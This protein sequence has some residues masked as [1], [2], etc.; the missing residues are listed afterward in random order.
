MMD[1]IEREAIYLWYYLDLQL[2]QIL[3]Y[4]ALGILLGSAV[5]VFGKRWIHGAFAGV[6]RGKWGWLGVV[7]ASL[8]GIASPLCM[9]GTLPIAASFSEKGVRDDHLAAFMM[10]SVL[11]NPQLLMYSAALGQSALLI[12]LA[13]CFLCGCA[14][15]WLVRACCRA[16][17]S[18][19]FAAFMPRRPGYAPQPADTL[20]AQCA[21]QYPGHSAVVL[22]G[23]CF[24]CPIPDSHPP[25]LGCRPVWR[26]WLWRA[27]GRDAGCSTV[28][29]RR[30]H[31]SA[32]DAMA[33]KRHDAG[34]CSRIY[35]HRAGDQ[36]H[37]SRRLED[38]VGRE[39]L[40]LYLGFVLAFSLLTGLAVNAWFAVA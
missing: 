21:A 4:W 19:T 20:S 16:S 6:G 22:S 35:A 14:A 34:Q 9:Y 31:H 18:L 7:P 13:S 23:R 3:P 8:L 17:P 36:D 1:W 12:R 10:S 30:R 40:F 15:G 2:R 32:V 38:R 25:R 37:Q 27:A 33:G 5:S 28:H 11:L 24:D 29:V 39:A 26:R